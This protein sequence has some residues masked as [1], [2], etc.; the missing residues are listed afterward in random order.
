MPHFHCVVSALSLT[1]HVLCA[2]LQVACPF[3]GNIVVRVNN[4]RS[5]AGGWLRLALRN[6]AGMAD[7]SSVQLARVGVTDLLCNKFSSLQPCTA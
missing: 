6:V 2:G 5:T 1:A 4:Y 7:V 3:S